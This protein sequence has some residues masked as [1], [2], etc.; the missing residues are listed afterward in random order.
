MSAQ[1][2]IRQLVRK[3]VRQGWDAVIAKSGHWRLTAP[4]GEQMTC[5]S[6]PKGDAAYRNAR[7]DARRLG[8]RI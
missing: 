5:A 4:T 2:D 7:S 6:S 8:A 1:K 3:L